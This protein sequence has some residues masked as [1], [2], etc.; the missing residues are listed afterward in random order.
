MSAGSVECG[1]HVADV[2]GPSSSVERHG[3]AG[4]GPHQPAGRR[5]VDTAAGVSQQRR[6]QPGERS[7]QTLTPE[8]GGA[9]EGR[10]GIAVEKAEWGR[11]AKDKGRDAQI[12][13]RWTGGENSDLR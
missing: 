1:L 5:G 4:R 7:Q 12:K 8:I 11:D 9:T 6:R 3:L 10:R 13:I 2:A